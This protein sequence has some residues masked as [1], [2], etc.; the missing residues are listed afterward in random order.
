MKRPLT[1]VLLAVLTVAAMR[2]SVAGEPNAAKCADSKYPPIRG[3]CSTDY[4]RLDVLVEARAGIREQALGHYFSLDMQALGPDIQ[5]L[6]DEDPSRARE[7]RGEFMIRIFNARTAS[8]RAEFWRAKQPLEVQLHELVNQR[9]YQRIADA[10]ARTRLKPDSDAWAGRIRA[11]IPPQEQLVEEI[12]IERFST[13]GKECSALSS[14]VDRLRMLT[15]PLLLPEDL[16][17]LSLHGESY[18]VVV[19]SYTT[20]VHVVA[21]DHL[22][23]LFEWA[24]E[25]VGA[26]ES[27]WKPG[28]RE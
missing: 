15:L 17:R 1:M 12:R 4:L 11:M 2:A 24:E 3:Y 28:V 18:D 26:L 27:C 10:F 23:P 8:P 20:Q 14:Q 22:H 6:H 7:W 5:I 16:P 21:E 19:K 13:S 9:L 25:T